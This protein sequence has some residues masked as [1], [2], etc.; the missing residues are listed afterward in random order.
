MGSCYVARLFFSSWLQVILLPWPP[1]V[2]GLYVSGTAPGDTFIYI[3]KKRKQYDCCI[4]QLLGTSLSNKNPKAFR[5]DTYFTH[6][7]PI[8]VSVIMAYL[9]IFIFI[10][11]FFFF[12]TR[13]LLL[14]P[15]LECNGAI[16]AHHNLHLLGS[17]NSLASASWVA[18]IIYVPPYLANL[19]FLVETG[20]LHV[21]QAGLKLPTSV[22]PPTL[23]FQSAGITGVNYK[24]PVYSLI[25]KVIAWHLGNSFLLFKLQMKKLL[26]C[27][28][29]HVPGVTRWP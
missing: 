6:H 11:F 15:R 7:K 29:K 20:F 27:Q 3:N 19:I 9:F 10:L 22:N 17:S 1:E 2:L 4:G 25:F 12:E 5:E 8:F 23:A 14:L 24:L 16:S 13:V 18:G 28:V 26:R 21:G